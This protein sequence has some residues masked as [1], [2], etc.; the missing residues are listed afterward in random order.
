MAKRGYKLQEFLA[1]SGN[2]NC[3]NI[4]KKGCRLFVTGGDDHRVNVWEI[5][6]PTSLKSLSGHISPVESVA[7]DSAEV[8]ILAGASSGVIK[9]WDLQEAKM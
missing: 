2:V 9:Q 3:L 7:F 4:G 5:G 8:L 6:K 1:H